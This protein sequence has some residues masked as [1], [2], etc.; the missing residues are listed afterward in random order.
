MAS[1]YGLTAPRLDQTTLE[2][3][4]GLSERAGTLPS[5]ALQFVASAGLSGSAREGQQ[6]LV[7]APYPST[8]ASVRPVLLLS[9]IAVTA[10]SAATCSTG[11][12]LRARVRQ[13]AV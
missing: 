7:T 4:I 3:A 9:T 8:A 13:R 6:L 2:F 1:L 12:P 11:L 10:V 5:Q